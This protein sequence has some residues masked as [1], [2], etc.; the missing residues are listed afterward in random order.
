MADFA[1]APQH[2]MVS[3]LEK[4]EDEDADKTKEFNL[5]AD[6]EV[7][8][9]DKDS[10]EKGGSTTKTVSTARPDISAARPEDSS[11]IAKTQSKA[12]LNEPNPHGKGSGHTPG[13]DEGIMILKEFTYLCT[14]LSQKVLDLEIVK[15]AQAKEIA[16]LKK[17]VTKLKQRQS[18]R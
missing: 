17:R 4:T 5:D 9:E 15:T 7:I 16:S 6:T 12:T 10:G 1:F 3:Y 18:S 2:N 11:N 14:T 8:V 13:S